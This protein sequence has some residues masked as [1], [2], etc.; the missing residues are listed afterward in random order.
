MLLPLK[1]E[2]RQRMK[3]FSTE[4]SEVVGHFGSIS[5]LTRLA[6]VQITA[7]S[8]IMPLDEE[9]IHF[10][11]ISL[12]SVLDWK[13][14]NLG[15]SYSA[16]VQSSHPGIPSDLCRF[17]LNKYLE[18][19]PV[20]RDSPSFDEFEFVLNCCERYFKLTNS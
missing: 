3:L 11:S 5:K 6:L 13:S 12:S 16:F 10:L 9:E 7:L 1:T 17:L 19:Q 18:L 2:L 20:L 14:E 4:L 15:Q 8:L